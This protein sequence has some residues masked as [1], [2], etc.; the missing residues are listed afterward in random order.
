METKYRHNKKPHEPI[1]KSN[2]FY[3]LAENLPLKN[4]KDEKK[5]K[6]PTKKY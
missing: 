6:I 5:K 2:F 1:E 3:C 4:T